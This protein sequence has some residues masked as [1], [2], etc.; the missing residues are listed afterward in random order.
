[1]DE[2]PLFQRAGTIP[3]RPSDY[4]PA[5][6]RHNAV[7]D[8]D[9]QLCD[10]PVHACTTLQRIA[11][12]TER[13]SRRRFSRTTAG[14]DERVTNDALPLVVQT[15]RRIAADDDHGAAGG[16]ARPNLFRNPVLSQFSD[17]RLCA[18]TWWHR[19]HPCV[20]VERWRTCDAWA[21]V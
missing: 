21:K 20:A 4:A 6:S 11:R 1:M 8:E 13:Q 12:P 5:A 15:L 19:G 14:G 3:A 17:V 7:R 18:A 2:H 9:G 10:R 16:P